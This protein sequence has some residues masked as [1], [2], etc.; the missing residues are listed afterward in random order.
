MT[1]RSLNYEK[2]PPIDA[3]LKDGSQSVEMNMFTEMSDM[4]LVTLLQNGSSDAFSEI[5]SR[6]AEKAQHLAMRITRSQ[7]DTEEVLQDVFVTVF[8][9]IDTF[10]GESAF[11]SW[12]YR[13]TA[14]TAF[15]KLR[16]RKKTA[17]ISLEDITPKEKESWTR[18]RSDESDIEHISTRHELREQ[19]Q[20]AVE[21][22][23]YE[24]R[25]I[26]VMRDVDGLSNE[27]VAATLSFS[28]AAV[29]SRLHRARLMLRKTLKSLYSAY[30]TGTNSY[31]EE[32]L[33]LAA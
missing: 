31:S 27:E 18:N 4:E 19:I 8:R 5:V 10:K 28:V 26:F 22:L 25:I 7:E 13:I 33:S 1:T 29:K 16:G 32:E 30:E 17:A 21:M 9:K 3:L 15:M 20:K 24:Y 14:N 23:P 11:S 6:Y 2:Y 12:L